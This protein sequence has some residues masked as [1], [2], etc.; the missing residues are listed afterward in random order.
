MSS[1][2]AGESDVIAS[3]D[4]RT[5]AVVSFEA[6]KTAELE[7]GNVST[8]AQKLNAPSCCTPKSNCR[9]TLLPLATGV[10]NVTVPAP[11]LLLK[12]PP[13]GCEGGCSSV[14]PLTVVT[15]PPLNGTTIAPEVRG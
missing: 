5:G 7:N 12:P 2:L 11:M 6:Q 10:A 9:S 13:F 3:D 4:V 14:V 8:T 1:L 15:P